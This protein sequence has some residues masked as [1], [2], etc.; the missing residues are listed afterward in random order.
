MFKPS[1]FFVLSVKAARKMLM[2]LTPGVNFI[3]NVFGAKILYE[4]CIFGFEI[5]GAKI[6]H[7]NCM[8]KTLMKLTPGRLIKRL[9]LL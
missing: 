8:Q 2:K 1:V 7:K 5:F 6:L 3:N 9:K 4:S